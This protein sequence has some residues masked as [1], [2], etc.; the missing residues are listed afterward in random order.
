MSTPNNKD[1]ELLKILGR[2]GIIAVGTLTFGCA[3]AMTTAILINPPENITADFIKRSEG[4]PLAMVG[5]HLRK[6]EHNVV[7]TDQFYDILTF[8]E[9]KAERQEFAIKSMQEAFDMIMTTF[10]VEFCKVDDLQKYYDFFAPHVKEILSN[11]CIRI[12]SD[13]DILDV[14][15]LYIRTKFLEIN[16]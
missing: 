11:Y 10:G 6:G 5:C 1:E 2:L 12:N 15:P 14:N 8:D 3:G 4:L 7:I 9:T 16:S 13:E